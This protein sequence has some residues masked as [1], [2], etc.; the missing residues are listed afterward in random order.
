MT[1]QVTHCL[2]LTIELVKKRRMIVIMIVVS[3]VLINKAEATIV[4]RK[5]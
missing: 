4:K 3:R 5:L 2:H 1:P